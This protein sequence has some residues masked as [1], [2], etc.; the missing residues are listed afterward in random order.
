M[1]L[2]S[3]IEQQIYPIF[4]QESLQFLEKIEGI[5]SNLQQ[6]HSDSKIQEL[7]RAAHTIKGGAA[8]VNLTNIQT[9][10]ARLEKSF[11]SLSPKN[12]DYEIGEFL[13]Q[14]YE[15]LRLSLLNQIQTGKDD[16][17]D[18]LAEAESIFAH[19]EAKLGQNPMVEDQLPTVGEVGEDV[20]DLIV[21]T[22]IVEALKSLE[23][24]LA[25]SSTEN[26]LQELQNQ[27]KIFL[28]LG[29]ILEISE[30]ITIAQTTIAT[31]EVN[32]Q[33]VRNIGQLALAGFR[34][35]QKAALNANSSTNILAEQLWETETFFEE[36]Q[37]DYYPDKIETEQVPLPEWGVVAE[38]TP[39]SPAPENDLSSTK[40]PDWV[41][42]PEVRE[43]LPELG[44]LPVRQQLKLNT[45]KLLVWQTDSTIFTLPY[46]QIKENLSRK[47]ARIIHSKNQKF[48]HWRSKLLPIYQ[49][50]EL[51][52]YK[53]PH[54]EVNST[55]VQKNR[56]T[57]IL[58]ISSGEL[59]FGLESPIERVITT[60]E[61]TIEPFGSALAP[62]C[63][64]YGCTIFKDKLPIPAIDVAALLNQ[65]IDRTNQ[66]TSAAQ[67]SD[68]PRVTSVD[69]KLKFPSST[70]ADKAPKVLVVDDS[71]T[72]RQLLSLALQKEGYQVLLAKDGREG[73]MQLEQNS[74][75]QL[76]ISDLEMPNVNG[77]EFL[78]HCRQQLLLTEVPFV[79][80]STCSS[81]RH[82]Q[83]ANNLGATAYFTKPYN[84]SELLAALWCILHKQKV[85]SRLLL[86]REQEMG[87]GEQCKTYNKN[88]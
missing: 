43:T 10:A 29:A 88:Y 64:I 32:P 67:L 45:A 79:F 51:L 55:T 57:S 73:I 5:L 31:L 63:Y 9:I 23:N 35:A 4:I 38:T 21:N 2:S 44:N 17:A 26:L 82:R 80:L 77:F 68:S 6:D 53:Y 36:E 70:S 28:D 24:I 75:I 85:R 19:L 47:F 13:L 12:I 84:E 8:Q 46:N 37:A 33:A 11:R 50:S 56:E 87:N 74:K 66:V 69:S 1:T 54:A 76:I 34:A 39:I 30:F 60:P 40:S 22:E 16:R 71:S 42:K 25:N 83:L 27:I 18:T 59:L 48:L 3:D 52:S 72:W 20:K 41:G 78:A 65:N 81:D 15:L 58:V 14:A 7:V 86:S 61:L 49:L 62:P